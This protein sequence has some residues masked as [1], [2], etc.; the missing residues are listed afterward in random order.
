MRRELDCRDGDRRPDIARSQQ[1]AREH[2]DAC[3]VGELGRTVE[4]TDQG[5]V[6]REPERCA[7]VEA[8]P[9]GLGLCVG[10][11]VQVGP[12]RELRRL[13]ERTGHGEL[14]RLVVGRCASQHDVTT[15][16][17]R[18]AGEHQQVRRRLARPGL[19]ASEHEGGRLDVAHRREPAELGEARARRSPVGFPRPTPHGGMRRTGRARRASSTRRPP[20]RAARPPATA[21]ITAIARLA[22]Q[23][24]RMSERSR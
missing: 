19:H 22:R 9:S 11:E 18:R 23:P 2:C 12:E 24:L 10:D 16:G 7:G 4:D 5:R 15:G 17:Q 20:T 8:V 6:E 14:A 21:T 3:V 13:I 1:A